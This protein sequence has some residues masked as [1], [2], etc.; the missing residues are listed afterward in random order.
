M[1]VTETQLKAAYERVAAF[2]FAKKA[3]LRLPLPSKI[4]KTKNK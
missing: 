1:I 4:G 2:E 3:A